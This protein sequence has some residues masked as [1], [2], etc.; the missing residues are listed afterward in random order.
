MLGAETEADDLG[1][2][3]QLGK[4]HRPM[5]EEMHGATA[6]DAT[7]APPVTELDTEGMDAVDAT[8]AELMA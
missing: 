4:V 2:L 8:L 6:D 5:A 7:G 3:S 1:E